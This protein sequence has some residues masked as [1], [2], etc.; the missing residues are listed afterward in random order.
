MDVLTVIYIYMYN[1]G[2]FNFRL[3]GSF[4]NHEFFFTIEVN[5]KTILCEHKLFDVLYIGFIYTVSQ[6][7]TNFETV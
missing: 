1:H 3:V 7:C 5:V 6:K 2:I 4:A